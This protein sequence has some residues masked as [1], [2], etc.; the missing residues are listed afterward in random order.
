VEKG[1]ALSP[2]AEDGLL[3]LQLADAAL[4]SAREGKAIN[5]GS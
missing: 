5:V 4:R 2:S 3:A 1:A